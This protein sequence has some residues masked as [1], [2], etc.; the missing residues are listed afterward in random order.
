[1]HAYVSSCISIR[2]I[3][4]LASSIWV[5]LSHFCCLF[6][7]LFLLLLECW[8]WYL[9]EYLMEDCLL[10]LLDHSGSILPQ[11][12]LTICFFISLSCYDLSLFV[13]DMGCWFVLLPQ[14]Y[15]VIFY[16]MFIS[17]LAATISASLICCSTKFFLSWFVL[18]LTFL[19][20]GFL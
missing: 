13:F 9:E 17:S 16:T 2:N 3:C 12:I 11:S 8:Y 1:M 19:S 10:F 18:F 7:V 20:V 15:L 14:R 6:V 4:S 5:C